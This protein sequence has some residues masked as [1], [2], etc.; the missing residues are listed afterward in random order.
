[1]ATGR[2]SNLRVGTNDREAAVA[3]LGTHLAEGRLDITEYTARCEAATT[4]TTRGDLLDLFEDLPAP[5]PVFGPR[6]PKSEVTRVPDDNPLIE[7]TNPRRT[8]VLVLS[9]L[10]VAVAAVITVAAVTSTWWAVAPIL[11]LGFVFI[12][13][14]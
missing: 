12:F 3:A 11:L 5:L 6:T 13:A 4:A 14:S 7:K 9:V 10:G 8:K 2:E 1:M